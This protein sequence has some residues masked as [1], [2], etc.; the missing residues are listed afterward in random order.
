MRSQDK[1]TD[2]KEIWRD[3][4]RYYFQLFYNH[5]NLH[6]NLLWHLY[7]KDSVVYEYNL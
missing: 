6:V 4:E 3:S 7:S 5:R 1:N 2:G